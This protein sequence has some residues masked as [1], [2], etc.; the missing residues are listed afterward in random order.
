LNHN[1]ISKIL[2]TFLDHDRR[3]AIITLI[4]GVLILVIGSA[5]G[6]VLF[7]SDRPGYGLTL[8]KPLED[9]LFYLRSFNR[10]SWAVP[11]IRHFLIDGVGYYW[12]D[13]IVVTYRILIGVSVS[14]G[15]F[16]I[17]RPADRLNFKNAS[18]YAF[19]TSLVF[20]ALNRPI[21][22]TLTDID[23][24]N[25]PRVTIWNIGGAWL[26]PS[27]NWLSRFYEPGTAILGLI[28]LILIFQIS[29]DMRTV[30]KF[31]TV[32]LFLGIAICSW[33]TI[34]YPWIG[35][36]ALFLT[37]IDVLLSRSNR[38][39]R[40]LLLLFLTQILISIIWLSAGIT[41]GDRVDRLGAV[42]GRI[43]NTELVYVHIVL[44][45]AAYARRRR[46]VAQV[47]LPMVIAST[48][49]IMITPLVTN[50][51]VGY[52][53]YLF[54]PTIVATAIAVD[55]AGDLIERSNNLI[56]FTVEFRRFAVLCTILI[57]ALGMWHLNHVNSPYYF[58]P[59]EIRAN[60][61][62]WAIECENESKPIYSRDP[63]VWWELSGRTICE[64]PVADGLS[65][66]T[67][68]QI[69]DAYVSSM[70]DSGL[71]TR[72]SMATEISM[73]VSGIAGSERQNAR[74][75]VDYNVEDRVS[76]HA[77]WWLF[78]SGLNQTE[79]SEYI[80]SLLINSLRNYS[81]N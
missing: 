65:N 35:V 72:D 49:A 29:R 59:D 4:S 10:I 44:L 60:V 58:V 27:G 40:L 12:A 80:E 7:T 24:F 69:A 33:S 48:L 62:N 68:S 81:D 63:A 61:E 6:N 3:L 2:S 43:A 18:K 23:N 16:L 34:S 22:V 46:P 78:H 14:V 8:V 15:L 66:L 54:V 17:F 57:L 5:I 55:I 19:F 42:T 13:V 67:N 9:E 53:H 37:G 75:M 51:T 74:N 39:I 20:T 28:G 25:T 31:R 45:A 21:F 32:L 73:I 64:N 71:K 77:V 38:R 70:L 56:Q 79:N 30:N 50:I 76:Y 26:L 41:E 11:S 47:A 36:V 1:L 52:W